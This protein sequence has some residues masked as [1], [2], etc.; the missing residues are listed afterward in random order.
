MRYPKEN[1]VAALISSA[2][3]ILLQPFLQVAQLTLFHPRENNSFRCCERGNRGNSSE[4]LLFLLPRDRSSKPHASL[5]IKI[6]L[7]LFDL[8]DNN[9]NNSIEKFS[10]KLS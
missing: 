4:S 7:R 9:N 6:K 3:L 8:D 2:L 1:K 10:D 5:L